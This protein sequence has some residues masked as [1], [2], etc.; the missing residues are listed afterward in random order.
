MRGSHKYHTRFAD[1]CSPTQ[2]PRAAPDSC[3]SPP[4]WPPP[5]FCGHILKIFGM[6][7][8]EH[9]IIQGVIK[10]LIALTQKPCPGPRNNPRAHSFLCVY[11]KHITR[12]SL[13]S[14]ARPTACARHPTRLGLPLSLS[15]LL[16]TYRYLAL[17]GF[18]RVSCGNGGIYFFYFCSVRLCSTRKSFICI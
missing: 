11:C 18:L 2:S 10:Q 16:R 15:T 5:H 3:S 8:G 6:L 9:N 1:T 13:I 4:C 12:T 14:V 7:R 17:W